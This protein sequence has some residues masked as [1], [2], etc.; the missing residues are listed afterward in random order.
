MPITAN[1]NQNDLNQ[2]AQY[3]KKGIGRR[4]WDVMNNTIIEQAKT[5]LGP[6]EKD[7]QGKCVLDAGCAEGILS[8]VVLQQLPGI[9]LT[10][11]D[12]DPINV[13]ICRDH[14]L[15][16]IQGDLYQIPFDDNTFDL[17]FLIAVIEH[18]EQPEKAL[19]EL[20]RVLKPGG[21]LIV[22]YP[23]DWAWFLARMACFYWREAFFNYGHL[24]QWTFRSLAA[25]L[26][27]NGMELDYKKASPFCFPFQLIG[28]AAA[29]KK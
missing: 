6:T 27:R 14:N 11:M 22:V 19:G 4:F 16:A 1:K 18:L 24:R 10:S 17:A 23:V 12:I 15:P 28:I 26:K 29:T 2:R 25:S 20:S 21:S 5:R 8:D 7:W 13:Q 3:Q 9:D